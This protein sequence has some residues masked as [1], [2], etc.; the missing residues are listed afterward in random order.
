MRAAIAKAAKS[1]I[2]WRTIA[3]VVVVVLATLAQIYPSWRWI[4][5][6]IAAA[7]GF[8]INVIPG[9]FPAAPQPPP[10]STTSAG[11]TNA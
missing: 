7:G 5:I 8:G 4:P 3:T 10:T 6:V 1:P 2:T 11:G 9:V